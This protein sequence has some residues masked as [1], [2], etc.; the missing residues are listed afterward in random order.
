MA[1]ERSPIVAFIMLCIPLV[2][3]YLFYLWWNE[4]KAKWNLDVN[5]TM[6]TVLMIIPIVNLYPIYM[7]LKLVDENLKAEGHEGYPFGP[8]VMLISFVIPIV[9]LYTALYC[10]AWKTQPMLSEAGVLPL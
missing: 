6:M 8:I 3:L 2:N 10:F 4:I 5:P 1:E 9:N 7:F